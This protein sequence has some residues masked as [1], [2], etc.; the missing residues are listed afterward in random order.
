MAF[1]LN[2]PSNQEIAMKNNK[3]T[4]I[5][6]Q[7]ETDVVKSAFRLTFLMTDAGEKRH[8]GYIATRVLLKDSLG[9]FH[10]FTVDDKPVAYALL[11]NGIG[12]N[13]NV[14]RLCYFAVER[15]E[16]NKGYAKQAIDLLLKEEVDITKGILTSCHPELRSFY[17]KLGFE[18][19]CVS[20]GCNG[21]YIT[22]A[23]VDKNVMTIADCVEQQ[24]AMTLFNHNA[25]PAF[26]QACL[27]YRHLGIQPQNRPSKRPSKKRKK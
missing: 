15:S 5:N 1:S 23:L 6:A 2:I 4:E 16:R 21:E 10:V 19:A 22:M 11:G 24:I 12:D 13:P 9:S 18:F 3:Y 14:R 17:E 27:D 20:D 25:E 8:I 7:N 26:R